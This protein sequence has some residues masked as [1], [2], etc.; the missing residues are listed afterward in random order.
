MTIIRSATRQVAVEGRSY[1]SRRTQ[2]IKASDMAVGDRIVDEKLGVIRVDFI[3]PLGDTIWVNATSRR[4]VL[5]RFA[6][7]QTVERCI[8]QSGTG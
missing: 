4:S 1:T 7:W 2:T 8:P 3:E 5:R 6:K